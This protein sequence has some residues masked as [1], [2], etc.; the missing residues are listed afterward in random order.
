MAISRQNAN[1]KTK[2]SPEDAST[3]TGEEPAPILSTTKIFDALG[4]SEITNIVNEFIEIELDSAETD[5]PGVLYEAA[6]QHTL[7]RNNDIKNSLGVKS[8]SHPVDIVQYNEGGCDLIL[9]RP[10]PN[11]A[12]LN[13]LPGKSTACYVITTDKKIYYADK[14]RK[15]L[16]P[17]VIN[18]KAFDSL[19]KELALRL[20]ERTD[21]GKFA[22][23]LEDLTSE[24]LQM[25]TNHTKH[26]H[27]MGFFKHNPPDSVMSPLEALN[28]TGYQLLAP[29]HFS[30]CYGVYD[31][32]KH[33][34]GVLSKLLPGFKPN[35][36]KPLKQ[37]HLEIASLKNMIKK[38][39]QH[40]LQ[41]LSDIFDIIRDIIPL[42]KR[43]VNQKNS[44]L[45]QAWEYTLNTHH[46]YL[47]DTVSAP[48]IK[49]VLEEF[50]TQNPPTITFGKLEE[51]RQIL[52]KRKMNI[53]QVKSSYV[54]KQHKH[55]DETPLLNKAI[56][57]L[58]LIL[59][60]EIALFMQHMHHIDKDLQNAWVD[61]KAEK[62]NPKGKYAN[63]QITDGVLAPLH[64]SL[65]D[66]FHYRILTGQAKGLTSGYFM[67]DPDRHA[68]NVARDGCNVD[69]DLAVYPLTYRFKNPERKPG[70]DDY[71]LDMIDY[72]YFPNLSVAKLRYWPTKATILDTSADAALSSVSDVT[73]NYYTKQDNQN[74][75]NLE[76]SPVFNFQ[77]Y[78]QLIIFALTN[79]QMFDACAKLHM[80]NQYPMLNADGNPLAPLP[81][82][83]PFGQPL[84]LRSQWVDCM[85]HRAQ[86]AKE[87]LAMQLPPVKMILARHRDFILEL[88][89]DHFHVFMEDRK[90][91]YNAEELK[92][93]E[94]ALR[95]D[96]LA[97]AFNRL[98]EEVMSPGL[99][100]HQ[101][102]TRDI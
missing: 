19:E 85:T 31:T 82:T 35:R 27:G 83:G 58:N 91:E 56:A 5:P 90:A 36:D 37:H 69:G 29:R 16:T 62:S 24:Q 81:L 25:I 97:I 43:E 9:S 100:W 26:L 95:P 53:E 28:S 41:Q 73:Q 33:Y 80:T 44:Y 66:V 65:T 87:K 60:D 45:Y 23:L 15:I 67:Q 21:A 38:R 76:K 96:T 64:I 92:N 50:V 99:Q 34:V 102:S 39:D 71:V 1:D 88:V 18:T 32:V 84:D 59:L 79:R 40:D 42:L 93:F 6:L 77:K 52:I 101:V 13:T 78:V 54:A 94:E 8:S 2:T 57:Q 55:D 22:C 48:H 20:K 7:E 61:V 70:P 74:Y 3:N 98:I 17:L 51:I 12:D 47:G 86:D 46:Y 11:N 30:S 14:T 10:F 89:L 75:Q 49:P 63:I 4:C 72:T 68:K